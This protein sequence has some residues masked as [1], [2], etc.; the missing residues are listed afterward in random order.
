MTPAIV[1]NPKLA[2]HLT[3]AIEWRLGKAQNAVNQVVVP[4]MSNHSNP[5]DS[6][7]DACDQARRCSAQVESDAELVSML[8]DGQRLDEARELLTGRLTEQADAAKRYAALAESATNRIVEDYDSAVDSVEQAQS[9]LSLAVQPGWRMANQ[10][11]TETVARVADLRC[12]I[13]RAEDESDAAREIAFM[14]SAHV[15]Q[16]RITRGLAESDLVR[17]EMGQQI[18]QIEAML[19]KNDEA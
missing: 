14:A 5:L 16:A 13:A 12:R 1:R 2:D 11:L 17:A 7:I 18:T 8:I 19:T 15:V 4:P 9:L 10:W 3:E 6:V